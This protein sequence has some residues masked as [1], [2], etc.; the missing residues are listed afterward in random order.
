M[1]LASKWFFHANSH[2]TFSH[3]RFQ[4]VYA[5]LPTTS[6]ATPS[7]SLLASIFIVTPVLALNAILIVAATLPPV[8]VFPYNFRVCVVFDS[9]TSVPS[10]GCKLRVFVSCSV[11][12]D[13][14]LVL[15]RL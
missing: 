4:Q 3:K 1:A 14:L 6:A 8:I 7:S 10:S 2:F 5:T 11:A 12:S 13:R 15:N 9:A